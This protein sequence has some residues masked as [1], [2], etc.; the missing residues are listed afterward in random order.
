[1]IMKSY[2]ICIKDKPEG[3]PTEQQPGADFKL[4]S[5]W[6]HNKLIFKSLSSKMLCAE[7]FEICHMIM[8]YY[9][10]YTFY[11]KDKSE[12]YPTGQIMLLISNWK[13]LDHIMNPPCLPSYYALNIL[14]SVICMISSGNIILIT[15]IT[16][17]QIRIPTGHTWCWFQTE[18]LL[19]MYKP[20][21]FL[22]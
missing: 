1:M 12:W 18:E 19:T 8:K 15:P 4:K 5:S 20:F 10:Y 7:H 14:K 3:R 21:C 16:Q 11:I 6:P 17:E 2:Y 9:S 13:A 22:S